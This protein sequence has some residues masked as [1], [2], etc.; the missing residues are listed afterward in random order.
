MFAIGDVVERLVEVCQRY[1]PLRAA[2]SDRLNQAGNPK[3][4][5]HRRVP[6]MNSLRGVQIGARFHL[7]RR[8]A[9]SVRRKSGVHLVGQMTHH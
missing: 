5:R 6:D 2:L 9:M 7:R 1:H 4:T 3:G 8:L